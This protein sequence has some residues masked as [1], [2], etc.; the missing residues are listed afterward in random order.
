MVFTVGN[1]STPVAVVISVEKVDVTLP[2]HDVKTVVTTV[3]A[4]GVST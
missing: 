2:V 4:T 1:P 3:S